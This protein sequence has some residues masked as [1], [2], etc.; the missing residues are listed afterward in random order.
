MITKKNNR[1]EI[2]LDVASRLFLETGYSA[3][4]IRH[5]AEGAGC[6]EAAIYY[7]FKDGKRELLRVVAEKRMSSLMMALDSSRGAS[8]LADFIIR[9]G[10]ELAEGREERAKILRWIA[11]E[12]P[13][14]TEEEIALH[15]QLY[16]IFHSQ[17]AAEVGRFVSDK[18]AVERLSW[19]LICTLLGYADL[20]INLGM[21]ARLHYVPPDLLGVLATA[22]STNGL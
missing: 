11:A 21:E 10:N 18:K 16:L 13:L 22:L 12:L 14:F 9:F 3:T 1:R 6:T 20:F 4:S 15:Q 7:H 2:I 17:I 8:S 19:L 5:I